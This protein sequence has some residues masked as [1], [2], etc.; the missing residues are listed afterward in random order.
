MII[1]FTIRKESK[2]KKITEIKAKASI[3]MPLTRIKL[4]QRGTMYPICKMQNA[5]GIHQEKRNQRKK[6]GSLQVGDL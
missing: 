1:F 2:R 5:R 6:S 4:I 3:N